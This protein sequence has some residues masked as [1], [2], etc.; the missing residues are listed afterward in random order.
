MEGKDFT[1][2]GIDVGQNHSGS[3]EGIP[4]IICGIL[5]QGVSLLSRSST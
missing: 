5:H 1:V 3:L 2:P 4:M